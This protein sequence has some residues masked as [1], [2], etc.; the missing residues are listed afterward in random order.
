MYKWETQKGKFWSTLMFDLGSPRM[1]PQDLSFTDDSG[2][3]FV[4]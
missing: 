2:K 3:T 1:L 4:T